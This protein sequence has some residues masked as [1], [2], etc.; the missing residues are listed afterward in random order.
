MPSHTR[1]P[2][3]HADGL[4]FEA[5]GIQ[6]HIAKIVPSG[7]PEAQEKANGD[8]LSS[9]PDMF[10][11]LSF[12]FEIDNAPE[13]IRRDAAIADFERMAKAALKKAKGE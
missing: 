13:L 2:W 6:R 5:G 3:V 4:I 10:E 9:A 7:V 11:V 12:Y 1:G 8:L